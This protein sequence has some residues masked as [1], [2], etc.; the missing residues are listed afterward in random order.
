MENYLGLPKGELQCHSHMANN[1]CTLQNLTSHC[2]WKLDAHV[3]T[4]KSPWSKSSNQLLQNIHI[5]VLMEPSVFSNCSLTLKILNLK[6]DND[7]A[8]SGDVFPTLDHFFSRVSVTATPEVVELQQFTCLNLGLDSRNPA[9]NRLFGSTLGTSARVPLGK[10][11]PAVEFSAAQTTSLTSKSVTDWHHEQTQGTQYCHN[12]MSGT[13][14]W[15]L[16]NLGGFPFDLKHPSYPKNSKR[17]SLPFNR[18]GSVTFTNQAHPDT[19]TWTLAP[20]LEGTMVAFPWRF[21]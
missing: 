9:Y 5:Q 18:D 11:V 8:S 10:G 15:T 16:E 1:K 17:S 13:F 20:D 6:F 19:I 2:Q 12:N 3:S 7:S 4:L 21:L 14:S